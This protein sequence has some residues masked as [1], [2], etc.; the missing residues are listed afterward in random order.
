M[1]CSYFINKY[2]SIIK[3]LNFRKRNKKII[4]KYKLFNIINFA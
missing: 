1:Y 2:E 4:F 3:N